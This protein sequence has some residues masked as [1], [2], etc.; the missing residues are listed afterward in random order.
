MTTYTYIYNINVWCDWS[1]WPFCSV[2]RGCL[3]TFSLAPACLV[4]LQ[5]VGLSP[6]FPFRLM[7]VCFDHTKKQYCVW[8]P[9]T[10]NQGKIN[11]SIILSLQCSLLLYV[12]TFVWML[13]WLIEQLDNKDILNWSWINIDVHL[14]RQQVTREHSLISSTW[15]TNPSH[16]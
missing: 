7:K 4:V 8:N 1:V 3:Q 12:K 15:Q 13:F 11:E 10:W 9:Q 16:I 6:S 14:D 2:A 5:L